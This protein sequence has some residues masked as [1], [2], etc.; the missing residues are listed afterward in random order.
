MEHMH[1]NE[2]VLAA[3]LVSDDVGDLDLDLGESPAS[4]A[5]LDKIHLGGGNERKTRTIEK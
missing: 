2:D 4:E 1:A 5:D 3:C